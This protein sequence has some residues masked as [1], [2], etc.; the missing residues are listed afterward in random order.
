MY[1]DDKIFEEVLKSG[2]SLDHYYILY[3][4]KK[5]EKIEVF[6]DLIKGMIN[7]LEKRGY[8]IKDRITEKGIELVGNDEVAA[9]EK[10]SKKADLKSEDFSKWCKSL[11]GKCQQKLYDLTTLRQMRVKIPGSS[12]AYSFLPG[13]IDLE[14]ILAKVFA[15]YKLSD[16][17]KVENTILSYIENCA[18]SNNWFPLLQYYIIRFDPSRTATSKLVAD[19]TGES[20][21]KRDNNSPSSQKFV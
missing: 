20:D 9:S 5:Q 11:H 3:K 19:M 12:K 8:C 17:E 2:L 16:R 6:P 13:D 10:I 14:K 7:I 15:L 18:K 21:E 4:M 1:I